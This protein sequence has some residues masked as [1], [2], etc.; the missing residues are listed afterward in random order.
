[1]V[2]PK[3]QS[4]WAMISLGACLDQGGLGFA[5]Y[6]PIRQRSDAEAFDIATQDTYPLVSFL[7]RNQAFFQGNVQD[8]FQ[9]DMEQSRV[10]SVYPVC[11]SAAAAATLGMF[12]F[13]DF[14][15]DVLEFSCEGVFKKDPPIA[16]PMGYFW[17]L[18][19]VELGEKILNGEL[20]V[21]KAN[22]E[23]VIVGV[24]PI[25]KHSTML[26]DA[27]EARLQERK[28]RLQEQLE[29]SKKQVCRDQRELSGVEVQ[30]KKLAQDKL[31][32]SSQDMDNQGTVN[33]GIDSEG[34][35][36]HGERSNV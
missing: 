30:L 11:S 34:I 7:A 9:R 28:R 27:T 8:P 16:H 13:K 31:G 26:K 32:G 5:C 12:A 25:Q 18:K 23:M 14:K 3:I 35:N 2:Q 29:E 33:Q 21:R 19:G 10:E 6:T 20:K 24:R 1:M 36:S 4:P 22:L 15:M 17:L